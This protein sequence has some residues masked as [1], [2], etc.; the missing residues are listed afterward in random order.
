MEPLKQIMKDRGIEWMDTIWYL[1]FFLTIM[2]FVAF[3]VKTLK[4]YTP[5]ANLAIA[6]FGLLLLLGIFTA[7]YYV[8]IFEEHLEFVALLSFCIWV[9]LLVG[10]LLMKYMFG[11]H[12]GHFLFKLASAL[13]GMCSV[14][15]L[16][17]FIFLIVK[18]YKSVFREINK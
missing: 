16:T 14:I 17:S 2:F 15:V 4:E 10:I 13:Y 7:I 5:R 18:I 11:Y 3:I 12:E 1:I 8:W 9:A 6:T